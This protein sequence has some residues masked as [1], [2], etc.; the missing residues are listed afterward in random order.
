MAG[1]GIAGLYYGTYYTIH[2]LVCEIQE[3]LFCHYA[4]KNSVCFCWVLS[5]A[6]ITGN[7]RVDSLA[8]TAT[9]LGCHCFMSPNL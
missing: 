4:H 3:W 6:G 5:H 8:H 7:E 1:I 9:V 2:L